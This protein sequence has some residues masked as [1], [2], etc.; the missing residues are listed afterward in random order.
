MTYEEARMKIALEFVQDRNTMQDFYDDQPVDVPSS[1][2]R[3]D[4]VIAILLKPAQKKEW[5]AG[6]KL[7]V[8][9]RDQ[10][11]PIDAHQEVRDRA[12]LTLAREDAGSYKRSQKDMLKNGWCR[13]VQDLVEEEK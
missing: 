8:I 6:G 9:M 3:A 13:V 11:L 5:K 1:N 12:G 4:K 7:G 10:N 2:D